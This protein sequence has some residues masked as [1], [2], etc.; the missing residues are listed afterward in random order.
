M[1]NLNF[2]Y[3]HTL[4]NLLILQSMNYSKIA[5]VNSL[6]EKL[7]S[8][9]NGR[10][11]EKA[12]GMNN[13]LFFYKNILYIIFIITSHPLCCVHTRGRGTYL[14]KI[15]IKTNRSYLSHLISHFS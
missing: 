15:F 3:K 5:R 8:F 10:V 14:L 13:F 4:Q 2:N 6:D 1:I 11:I 7:I 9:A 12:K